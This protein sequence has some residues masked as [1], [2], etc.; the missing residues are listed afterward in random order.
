MTRAAGQHWP[1]RIRESA[2]SIR[3]GEKL[4]LR[5]AACQFPL[6]CDVEQNAAFVKRQ[7]NEAAGRGADIVQFPECALGG[8]AGVNFASFRG[9]DWSRLH[10][11]T[12]DIMALAKKLK[13]WVVLG[14]HHRLSGRH[15]PHNSLYVI[16]NRGRIVDR[17][18][19]MFCM[20]RV[21]TFDL[22]HYTPGSRFVVFRIKGVKCGL[23]IC[24]E[25]RY[26]ELYRN[27]QRLGVNIVFQSWYDGDLSRD[28][29]QQ[30]GK[31]LGQVIPAAAQGHAV[32]N[33]LWISGANTSKPESCFGCFVVQPD[34]IIAAKAARNRPAVLCHDID[35]DREFDDTAR[36]WRKRAMEG[37]LHS[38]RTV[39]DPRSEDPTCL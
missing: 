30:S 2:A 15:K 21:G 16:D 36:P 11:C 10:Q 31:A 38:G 35:T 4:V 26:P 17:Y 28:A 14:S 9:Y 20:G 6:G 24:H 1:G 23:L 29:F 22:A 34:G 39:S 8:Y 3:K 25:W 12:R 33:C 18:D 32:C 19:K 7:I 27:Y 37:V 13:V 5:I